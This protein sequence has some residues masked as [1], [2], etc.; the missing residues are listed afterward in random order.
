M[1]LCTGYPRTFAKPHETFEYPTTP[2]AT[3]HSYVG[4]GVFQEVSVSSFTVPCFKSLSARGVQERCVNFPS[5]E[6]QS[7]P[8]LGPGTYR[9]RKG[10]VQDISE[11]SISY[12]NVRTTVPRFTSSI[13]S[14][15]KDITVHMPGPETARLPMLAPNYYDPVLPRTAGPL[16]SEDDDGDVR[17]S[18]RKK[19]S[20]MFA[21]RTVRFPSPSADK[22][23]LS[24][25]DSRFTFDK[26]KKNW[27]K[28]RGGNVW[29]RSSRFRRPLWM[30]EGATSDTVGPANY[31]PDFNTSIERRVKTSPQRYSVA[32][33]STHVRNQIKVDTM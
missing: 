10:L 3:N 30:T 4:G 8:V 29:S 6:T 18:R 31:T 12:K 1:S 24:Q 19:G 14:V 13:G 5:S 32:F 27:L 28:S 2:S 25:I 15:R 26:E 20:S 11:S 33:R 7:R 21:S 23:T 17:S 16:E 22:K 9:E